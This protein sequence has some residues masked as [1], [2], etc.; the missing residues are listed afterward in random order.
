MK[1]VIEL[2]N[3]EAKNINGGTGPTNGVIDDGSG[4][5][6]TRPN[7]PSM[8]SFPYPKEIISF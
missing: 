7:H 2:T 8:P 5:G 1:N 6:C 4:N 3:L